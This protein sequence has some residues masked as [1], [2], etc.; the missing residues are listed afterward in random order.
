[1]TKKYEIISMTR[2][3]GARTKHLY[4]EIK[5]NTAHLLTAEKGL[6]KEVL[7]QSK[8]HE[9]LIKENPELWTIKSKI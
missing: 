1:M 5:D 2:Y 4:F 3:E 7:E 6:A 9:Q 8:K